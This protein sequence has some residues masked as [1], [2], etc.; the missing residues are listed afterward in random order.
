[1]PNL[2]AEKCDHCGRI[3]VKVDSDSSSGRV[4][5]QDCRYALLLCDY[6]PPATR[7]PILSLCGKV[8]CLECVVPFFQR[9]VDTIRRDEAYSWPEST[10]IYSQLIEGK[11]EE[12][13]DGKVNDETRQ[14]IPFS[15][16]FSTKSE[17]GS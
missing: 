1:M 10:T 17:G 16:H 9:W 14:T 7:K 15:T 12:V 13:S 3:V 11:S 2:V 6:K 5:F 8:L 4:M